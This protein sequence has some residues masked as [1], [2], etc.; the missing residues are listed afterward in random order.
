MPLS[1][2]N[3]PDNKNPEVRKPRGSSSV[4]FVER[5]QE[6]MQTQK[7][8]LTATCR[9]AK[10]NKSTLYRWLK[11]ETIPNLT[12]EKSICRELKLDYN[13]FLRGE[14]VSTKKTEIEGLTTRLE[15]ALSLG[16]EESAY[17]LG[18]AL[19]L[20]TYHYMRLNLMHP[21][22]SV[23]VN[24]SSD[25]FRELRLSYHPTNSIVASEV[26]LHFIFG[27]REGGG[28]NFQVSV[29]KAAPGEDS[30]L[31]MSSTMIGLNGSFLKNAGDAIQKCCKRI[32]TA[33]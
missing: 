4:L 11:G 17:R 30:K 21:D 3:N 1:T 6:F 9:L 12:T 25:D 14:W 8:S 19:V 5:L 26:I 23:S 32:H 27:P 2:S 31:F 13:S 33:S 29:S 20:E 28:I 16:D 18:V 10:V 22:D 7:L 15:L 24:I